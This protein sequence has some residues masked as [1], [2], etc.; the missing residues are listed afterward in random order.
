MNKVVEDALKA[1]FAFIGQSVQF[2]L[3]LIGV[4][5]VTAL[6]LCGEILDDLTTYKV[7]PIDWAHVAKVAVPPLAVAVGAYIKHRSMVAVALATP[8]PEES[9]G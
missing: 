1:T 8:A 6:S 5:I 2:L 3:G 7:Q 4:V 9:K